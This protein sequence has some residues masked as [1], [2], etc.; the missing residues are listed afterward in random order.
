MSLHNFFYFFSVANSVDTC[1]WQS[2][3]SSFSNQY[4]STCGHSAVINP[5][6][7]VT[8]VLLGQVVDTFVCGRVPI[9]S[10]LTLSVPA[11]LSVNDS[12]RRFSRFMSE[13]VDV[14][15]SCTALSDD[16]TLQGR[17]R[18][19]WMIWICLRSLML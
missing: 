1:P 13:P 5:S 10:P 8:E 2:N 4:L 9:R 18:L 3:F 14:V 11:F 19:F 15:F 7:R 16:G 6:I 12:W 17:C